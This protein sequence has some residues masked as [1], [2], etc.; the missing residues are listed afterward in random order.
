MTAAEEEA[1]HIVCFGGFR[2]LG[3][4]PHMRHDDMAAALAQLARDEVARLLM[5]H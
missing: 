4:R 3:H 5:P 2:G 1:C